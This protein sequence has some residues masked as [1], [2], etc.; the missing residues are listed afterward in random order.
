VSYCSPRS[1]ALLHPYFKR[2]PRNT[3]KSSQFHT[4]QI[5]ASNQFVHEPPR[6]IEYSSCFVDAQQLW[7]I[8]DRCESIDDHGCEIRGGAAMIVHIV[9]PSD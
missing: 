7:Q 1:I 2:S 6:H 5:A 3:Y 8:S 4:R 9:R